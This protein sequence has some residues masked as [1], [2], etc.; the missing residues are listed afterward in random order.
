[1]DSR[2]LKVDRVV[3][4]LFFEV[5]LLLLTWISILSDAAGGLSVV[6]LLL[7]KRIFGQLVQVTRADLVIA[8]L[9]T[10]LMML[11]L[12]KLLVVQVVSMLLLWPVD[13]LLWLLV[14]LVV[15]GRT[16]GVGCERRGGRHAGV[17]EVRVAQTVLR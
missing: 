7:L 13:M 17:V 3:R 15:I 10:R 1:M 12:L 9:V 4:S 14:T 6:L 8:G 2:W 5:L 11:R 16:T